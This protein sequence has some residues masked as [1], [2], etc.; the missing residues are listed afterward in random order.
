MKGI[1]YNGASLCWG[2]LLLLCILKLANA[3]K[4]SF[5]KLPKSRFDGKIYCQIKT[6]CL[7]LSL[8]SMPPLLFRIIHWIVFQCISRP[9]KSVLVFQFLLYFNC[10]SMYLEATEEECTFPVDVWVLFLWMPELSK[11]LVAFLDLS[12]FLNFHRSTLM[13]ITCDMINLGARS[14]FL[15][16]QKPKNT[17]V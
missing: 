15:P 2:L 6:R 14:K 1:F 11:N 3:T 7:L 5:Y 8:H 13:S 17:N 16:V 10:I 9:Q 4:M 12:V